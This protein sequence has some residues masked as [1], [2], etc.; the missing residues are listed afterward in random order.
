MIVNAAAVPLKRTAV[1]LEKFCPC[2]TTAVP[3]GPNVGAKLSSRGS[4][5]NAPAL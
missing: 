2:S 3:A 1:A 5:V 4:T